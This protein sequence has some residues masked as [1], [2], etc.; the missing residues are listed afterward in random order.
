MIDTRV[1]HRAGKARELLGGIS[2]PT[3]YKLLNDG[4]L[5]GVKMGYALFIPDDE[6]RRFTETLPEYVSP[7]MREIA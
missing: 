2:K 5:K 3:L 6:I 1:L 4:K 7:R